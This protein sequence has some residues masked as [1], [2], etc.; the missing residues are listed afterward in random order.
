MGVD[1]MYIFSSFT[2]YFILFFFS[3]SPFM[4]RVLGQG[5]SHADP[6]RDSLGKLGYSHFKCK[7][8]VHN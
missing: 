7:F 6:M 2:I 4:I 8:T 1:N 3:H 5:F